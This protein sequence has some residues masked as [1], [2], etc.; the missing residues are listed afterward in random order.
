MPETQRQTMRDRVGVQTADNA[1]DTT[2]PAP[3]APDMASLVGN[4]QM[5][6]VLPGAEG[7][8]ASGTARS[9]ASGR[10]EPATAPRDGAWLKES[11]KS[12]FL[13]RLRQAVCGATD[14]G[15]AGTGRTSAGCP[16]IERMFAYYER[17]SAARVEQAIRRYAPETTVATTADEMLPLIAARARRAAGQWALSGELSNV[18]EE[19]GF[20]M[21]PL[22]RDTGPGSPGEA[23]SVAS[24]LGPGRPLEGAAQSRMES[25]FG[26]SFAHV[27]VHAETSEASRLNAR[28][29]AVGNQVGFAPGEYR[30]GTQEGDALLAHELAHVAQ[31]QEGPA[32]PAAA[33]RDANRSA[34]RA[35]VA[36]WSSRPGSGSAAPRVSTGLRLSRCDSGPKRYKWKDEKLKK[37]VDDELTGADEIYS[38]VSARTP[39]RRQEALKDLEEGRRD[40]V[41]FFGTLEASAEGY[42][43][44]GDAIRKLDTVISLLYHDVATSQKP[45]F[46]GPETEFARGTAPAELMGGTRALSED[47]KKKVNAAMSPMAEVDPQTGKKVKFKDKVDG[48]VFKDRLKPAVEAA[49]ARQ[50]ASEFERRLP[51]RTAPGGLMEWDH[52]EKIAN[53][54]QIET[55]KVFGS[56]GVRPPF[57][58]HVNIVDRWEVMETKIAAMTPDVKLGTARA[59]V[60]KI[61]KDDV[62]VQA[63]YRLHGYTPGSE[64]EAVIG[65]IIDELAPAH[66][67]ELLEIHQ[68]WPAAA[69]P[70]TVE[71]QRDLPLPASTSAE[72]LAKS[73]RARRYRLYQAFGTMVHEYIHTLTHSRYNHWVNTKIS[74]EFRQHTMREGMTDA[75]TKVVLEGVDFSNVDLRKVIEGSLFVTS[76]DV[77]PARARGYYKTHRNAEAIIAIVG[78]QNAMAAYFLGEIE[79][80]GGSDAP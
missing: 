62:P 34:V 7:M 70:G 44:I 54:A 68:G 12:R 74:D 41:K 15:L 20:A 77:D 63:I 37:M 52:L 76:P 43:A 3:A 51:S 48:T 29:F 78:L 49:I 23:A 26:R 56:Y 1:K 64:G 71:I 79:L 19:P 50:H 17:Q 69:P 39:A 66:L 46:V 18:P 47:E 59:R 80:V 4:R 33:E 21:P 42:T 38:T 72:D 9:A 8:A 16:Y 36:L 57:A 2:R 53:S 28:A 40:Y 11:D 73:D 27:R 31:Q 30:P 14:E 13:A 61:L 35:A 22:S 60:L 25:A 45:G 65:E 24:R 55:G 32:A 10:D 5:L 6:A 58:A 67:D 75:F